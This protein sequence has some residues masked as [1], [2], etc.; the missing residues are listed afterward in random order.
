[1]E[2]WRQRLIEALGGVV[3]EEK[4]TFVVDALIQRSE[5]LRVDRLG[6]GE[7]DLDP[8]GD[9]PVRI[10]PWRPVN[11]LGPMRKH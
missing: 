10:D 7:D 5:E 3:P 1:M 9:Q 6:P 8:D 2:R 4:S 11:T